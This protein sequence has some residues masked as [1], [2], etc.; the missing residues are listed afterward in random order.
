MKGATIRLLKT[1]GTV[2]RGNIVGLSGAK[3]IISKYIPQKG[4]IKAPIA[5]SS[6]KKLEVMG[7]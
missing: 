6:I 5:F 7:K 4:I 2:L 1:D 3:L